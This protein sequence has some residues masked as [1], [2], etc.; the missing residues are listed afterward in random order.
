MAASSAQ[1]IVIGLPLMVSLVTILGTI[2]IHA[3]ALIVIVHFIRRQHRLGRI[4]AGFWQDVAIV[5]TATVLAG[6]AHL[7]EI[8]YVGPGVCILR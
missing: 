7:F 6:A 4:G 8:I 2:V 1:D 3:V 5:C